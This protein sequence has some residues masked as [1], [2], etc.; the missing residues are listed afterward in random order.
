MLDLDVPLRDLPVAVIDTETTHPD[1]L[2][3]RIVELAVVA[4]RLGSPGLARVVFASRVNPGIPIPPDSTR[5]HGIRDEDVAG[6]PTFEEILRDERFILAL[7][8]AVPGAYN[9]PYDFQVLQA[10]HGRL[11]MPAP[12]PWLGVEDGLFAWFDLLPLAKTVDR[13]EKGRFRHRLSAVLRRRGFLLDAHGAAGDALGSAWLLDPIL[14]EIW[15]DAREVPRKRRKPDL[16]AEHVRT[17]LGTRTLG[18]YLHWQRDLALLLE[19]EFVMRSTSEDPV[20]LPWHRLSGRSA[21]EAPPP[22]VRPRTCVSC[23]LPIVLSIDKA[24]HLVERDA[25]SLLP[26]RHSCPVPFE[27]KTLARFRCHSVSKTCILYVREFRTSPSG[28]RHGVPGT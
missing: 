20:D 10:E 11:A 16:L 28:G 15:P 9:S 24:G 19:V 13:W 23:H 6:A 1:P 25:G 26:H 5:V 12:P 3:A 14:R 8:G 21:P 17:L 4:C 7:Q 27:L 2:E 18:G 22:E